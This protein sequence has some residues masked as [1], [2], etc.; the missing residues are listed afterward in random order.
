MNF[1]TYSEQ[2]T[3]DAGAEIAKVLK[4]GDIVVLEG[5]LGAG[6][7]TLT[8]GIIQ[9][10]GLKRNITSPTFTLM[11]V[12]DMEHHINNIEKIVHIDTYRLKDSAELIEIGAE[13]Y[14]GAENVLTL[15]EWPEKLQ[16]L[17]ANKPIMEISIS[18]SEENRRKIIVQNHL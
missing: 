1:V 12:Y 11:N 2:K 16:D 10:L 6:K 17:L 13:D 7:S 14:I 8:R 4:G 5:K 18:S 9:A 15:I 3:L